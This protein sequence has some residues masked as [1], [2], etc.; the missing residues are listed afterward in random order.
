MT[1]CVH[2]L[3]PRGPGSTI[4]SYGNEEVDDETKQKLRV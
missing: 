3:F 2:G 4:L 1:D